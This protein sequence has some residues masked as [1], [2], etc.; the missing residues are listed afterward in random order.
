MSETPPQSRPYRSA[1][2]ETQAQLTRGLILDALIH[3]LDDRPA[4]EISTRQLAEHAGVSLRTVYRHFP[5][6]DSLLNGLAERLATV[7]GTR[8]LEAALQ[9]ID[10]LGPM[11]KTMYAAN[12]DFAALVRAEVLFNCDPARQAQES[13]HRTDR[14]TALIATAFPDIDARDQRHLV[15]LIRSLSAGRTWLQM[16]EGFGLKGTQSGPLVAWAINALLAE[17]RRGN[18]P[19][20]PIVE[21]DP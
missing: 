14:T 7:M 17:A 20:I 2:R 5:D 6:R 4:D 11:I 3:L 12:D 21:P 15:A 8:D 9:T 16:R 19:R 1:L 13:R 10:D 18:L